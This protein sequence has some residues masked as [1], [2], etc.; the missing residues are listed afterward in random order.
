MRLNEVT[1]SHVRGQSSPNLN[2]YLSAILLP[3]LPLARST[4]V[5]RMHG[6][7]RGMLSSKFEENHRIRFRSGRLKIRTRG[8]RRDRGE[9]LNAGFYFYLFLFFF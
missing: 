9:S 4:L 6:G 7:S 2:L 5:T 1:R 8:I 3:P